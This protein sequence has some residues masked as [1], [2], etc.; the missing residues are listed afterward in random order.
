MF[1]KIMTIFSSAK[2]E[3]L[4]TNFVRF[5][6]TTSGTCPSYINRVDS[7]VSVFRYTFTMNYNTV[8]Y[9]GT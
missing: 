8:V 5:R 2:Y 3:L 6:M 1:F 7:F 9:V 4:Q